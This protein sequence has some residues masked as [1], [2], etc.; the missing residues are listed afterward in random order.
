M[1]KHPCTLVM[2]GKIIAENISFN[3]AFDLFYTMAKDTG[4][5]FTKNHQRR[6]FYKGG[7]VL[8]CAN[9]GPGY[10]KPGAMYD[11]AAYVAPADI[12]PERLAK[13]L[14]L[15]QEEFGYL[16]T[17]GRTDLIGRILKDDRRG[18]RHLVTYNSPLWRELQLS[19]YHY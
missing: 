3:K 7:Y 19:D 16:T 11:S 13:L 12:D 4:H 15:A 6:I 2:N 8:W 17:A 9:M 14:S 1:L 10:W 18:M 5:E